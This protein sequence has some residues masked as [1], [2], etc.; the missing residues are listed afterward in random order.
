MSRKRLSGEKAEHTLPSER[1]FGILFAAVFAVFSGYAYYKSSPLGLVAAFAGAALVFI[2]AAFSAPR[3][4]R[5]LNRVWF[6]IG[7]L[8]SRVVN[9]I[10]LG[11][12]YFVLITPVAIISRAFGRDELGL[13]TRRGASHWVEREPGPA[14][15]SFKNQF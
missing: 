1:S 14:S 6:E 12:I 5:P 8:L 15:E 11:F 7:R 9:P 4:L 3:L 10:V 2:V 13:R